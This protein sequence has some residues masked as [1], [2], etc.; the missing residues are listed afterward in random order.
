MRAYILHL[1]EREAAAWHLQGELLRIQ[2]LYRYTVSHDWAL[3]AKKRSVCLDRSGCPTC[4]PTVR[5][6]CCLGPQNEPDR[7]TLICRHVKMWSGDW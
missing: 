4:L 5:S 7:Q 6:A 1:R 3:F 2:Y